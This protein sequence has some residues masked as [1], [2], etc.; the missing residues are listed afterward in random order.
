M[1]ASKKARG[2]CTCKFDCFANVNYMFDFLES[3][4]KCNF[5]CLVT[6]QSARS[7]V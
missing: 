7:Y 1:S 4:A 3:N 6:S 5:Y 2:Y